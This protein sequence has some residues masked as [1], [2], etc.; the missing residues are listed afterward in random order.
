MN[1]GGKVNNPA[2]RRPSGRLDATRLISDAV[3][4]TAG[5]PSI[6]ARD[7]TRETIVRRSLSTPSMGK[8]RQLGS[9]AER[10]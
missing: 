10:R 9:M 8:T 3:A 5:A 4:P 7:D 2:Q 6:I 1:S